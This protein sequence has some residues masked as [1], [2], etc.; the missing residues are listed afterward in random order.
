MLVR[1]F[2]FMCSVCASCVHFLR[3]SATPTTT[4]DDDDETSPLA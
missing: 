2:M 3:S 1:V 4:T